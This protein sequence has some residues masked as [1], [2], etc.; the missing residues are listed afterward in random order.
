M[1]IFKQQMIIIPGLFLLAVVWSSHAYAQTTSARNHHLGAYIGFTERNDADFTFGAEYAY[2]LHEQWSFGAIVEHTPN[3][4]F[5]RD[6][7]LLL[8][9]V[10]FRTPAVPR[11]K[12]TGGAGVEFKDIGGNDL[13]F[14]AGVGYDLISDLVTVTPRIGVDFGQGSENMVLGVTFYY[15]L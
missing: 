12:L 3:Y 6:A 15:G 9:T 11:L 13:R 8:G 1:N 5:S 14:R 7:T 10:N 4:L 2:R